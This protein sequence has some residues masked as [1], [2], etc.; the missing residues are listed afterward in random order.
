GS[1]LQYADELT[2]GRSLQQR[3]VFDLAQ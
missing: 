1:E 2:L 3:Q